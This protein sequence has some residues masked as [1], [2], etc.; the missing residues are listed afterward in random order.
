MIIYTIFIN[1]C[2]CSNQNISIN[3]DDDEFFDDEEIVYSSNED[4]NIKVEPIDDVKNKS[5]FFI[6]FSWRL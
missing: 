4:I 5:N 2:L 6:N 3:N 1:L